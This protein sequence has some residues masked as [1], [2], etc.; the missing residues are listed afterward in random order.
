MKRTKYPF[1][2]ALINNIECLVLEG[3]GNGKNPSAKYPYPYFLRH[4]EVDWMQPSSI[5]RFVLVNFFGIAYASK[6]LLLNGQEWVDVKS[7]VKEKV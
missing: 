7:F 4:G 3:I 1:Y 6:P 5:E 2:K